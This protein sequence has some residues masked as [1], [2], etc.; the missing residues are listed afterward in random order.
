MTQA[1]DLADGKFDTDTLVVDAA[2][3]AVGIGNTTP[4]SFTQNSSERLVVGSGSGSQGL[5]VYAGN[6]SYSSVSFADGTS[7]AQQYAGFLNYNH[8]GDLLQVG[9]GGSERARFT[10]NGLTFNGDTATANALSDY[11][12]GTFNPTIAT[13]GANVAY[14][15]QNGIYTKV[16]RAV[17]FNFQINVGTVTSQGSG[18]FILGGLPF[19]QGTNDNFGRFT[20]QTNAV[21]FNSSYTFF[22]YP[23]GG[24][25]FRILGMADNTGWHVFST[26]D[27]NISN[28][29]IIVVTG[30]YFT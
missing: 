4:N 27:F 28:G 9:I 20:V 18:D 30:T 21:N 6:A 2:N 19:T 25:A 14:S 15:G 1:R 10:T 26:S 5:T 12:E 3:N 17:H 22:A 23:S 11:E 24:V 29:S 16:G 7:G 13:S 8:N